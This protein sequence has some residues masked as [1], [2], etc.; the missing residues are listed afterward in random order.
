MVTTDGSGY[1]G[2]LTLIQLRS[3]LHKDKRATL[4]VKETVY[5]ILF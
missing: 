3:P 1:S 4:M 5:Y 2:T